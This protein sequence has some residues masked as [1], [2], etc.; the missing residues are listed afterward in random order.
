[1]T[2]ARRLRQLLIAAF[3]FAALVETVFPLFWT[4]LLSLKHDYQAFAT[5]PLFVFN[6]TPQNYE[7]VL[8][9]IVPY[10]ENSVIAAAVSAVLSIAAGCLGAYAFSRFRIRGKEHVMFLILT[11]LMLPP[12]VIAV[13]LYLL[14]TTVGIQ[15][16]LLAV[17]LAHA[18]FNTPF[19]VWMMRAFFDDI[20]V[21]I[22]E[23]AFV[24]GASVIQSF[25]FVAMP[26]VQSGLVAT[27]TLSA[28]YSWSE[29]LLALVM[30]GP[31]SQTLPVY[32]A[33]YQS[34]MLPIPW[35][36][37]AA[38]IVIALL[39]LAVFTVVIQRQLVRGLTFGAVKG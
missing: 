4:L 25:A 6:P 27:A 3:I 39:P 17:I 34:S 22:E 2:V 20:P 7:V 16:S 26:L 33:S 8:P 1:M 28:F 19:V 9:E 18:L 11:T 32:V 24:D 31:S 38:T 15:G 30:S 13:P 36:T 29:F 14:A 35:T 37:L 21:E 23:A 12:I 5:P 10:L